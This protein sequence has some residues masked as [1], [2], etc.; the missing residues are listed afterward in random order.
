MCISY[1]FLFRSVWYHNV[2][3]SLDANTRERRRIQRND[4]NHETR[5]EIQL[6]SGMQLFHA[7]DNLISFAV[8]EFVSLFL[9]GFL[10]E[11]TW[12][13][14]SANTVWETP[15]SQSK[16]QCASY[17]TRANGNGKARKCCRIT[18]WAVRARKDLLVYCTS[19]KHLHCKIVGSCFCFLAK[20]V[21]F[22]MA[23]KH[24]WT[25]EVWSTKVSVGHFG[26]GSTLM[27][28]IAIVL[29]WKNCQAVCSNKV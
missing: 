20:I 16:E 21:V 9:Y 7:I 23:W 27:L 8:G 11:V 15:L 14:W 24:C 13:L 1:Q 18:N 22:D 28:K 12:C 17:M 26:K 6:D 19:S 10:Q 4:Q 29:I 25:S 3:W 5:S 2:H